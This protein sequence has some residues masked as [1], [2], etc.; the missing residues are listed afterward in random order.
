MITRETKKE[1]KFIVVYREYVDEVYQFIYARSGFGPAL[2]E[3]ITQDIFLDVFKGLD[4]FKGLCSERTWI[5]RITRNK[6]NDFYRKQYRKKFETCGID[7]AAQLHDLSQDVEAQLVRSFESRFVR[8]CLDKLPLHYRITLLMKYV[9]GK[10]I[11]QIAETA[12][13]SPKAAESML[14]RA[15]GTFIKEYQSSIKREER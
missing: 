8:E 11:K 2:A 4:K 6:L 7:N 13:I 9:D 3:D 14:Q 15:K 5:F 12:D 1:H 10:S